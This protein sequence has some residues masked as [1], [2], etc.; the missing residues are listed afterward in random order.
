MSNGDPPP[1][2]SAPYIII[3][4]G[5]IE[6]E[7]AKA[8]EG[9][10]VAASLCAARFSAFMQ[11]AYGEGIEDALQPLSVIQHHLMVSFYQMNKSEAEA[12]IAEMFDCMTAIENAY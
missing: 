2:S 9:K 12:K 4:S 11:V 10:I 3:C 5:R 8:T 1:Q 6:V 7:S